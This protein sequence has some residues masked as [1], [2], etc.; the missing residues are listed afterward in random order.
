MWM[1]NFVNVEVFLYTK[2]YVIKSTFVNLMS[3][4]LY[5]ESEKRIV[6]GVTTKCPIY[7]HLKLKRR[8]EDRILKPCS[9]LFSLLRHIK[10]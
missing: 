10:L 2:R 4:L 3:Y 8:E 5:N 6:M 1:S 9:D 7:Q